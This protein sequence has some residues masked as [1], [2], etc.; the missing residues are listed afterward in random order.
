MNKLSNTRTTNENH[1]KITFVYALTI[2]GKMYLIRQ[3]LKDLAPLHMGT[4]KKIHVLANYI[5]IGRRDVC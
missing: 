5:K 2:A 1:T 4:R 3:L